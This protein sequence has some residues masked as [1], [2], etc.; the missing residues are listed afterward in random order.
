[1]ETRLG[2]D[3]A[4]V[5][6]VLSEQV[7]IGLLVINPSGEMEFA[8]SRARTLLGCGDDLT[9][10][11]CHTDVQSAIKAIVS[12]IRNGEVQSMQQEVRFEHNGA[13]GNIVLEAYAIEEDECSG[14][15]ILVKD[16]ASMRRMAQDLRMSAQF[17]NTRRLYQ[18]V[19]HDLRQPISAVMVHLDLLRERFGD[20]DDGEVE[21]NPP[22]K[23]IGVIRNQVTDL[24][25]ALTLLLEEIEPAETE[26]RGFSLRAVLEDVIRLIEPQ[27]AQQKV[28]MHVS[29][30]EHAARMSGSRQRIKQALLNLAVNA[31]DAM[32]DGGMLRVK[33]TVRGGEA[34]ISF[35]DVGEGIEPSVLP[36]IFEM[37][38]TTKAIG[39]GVGLYVARDVVQRHGGSIQVDTE[40]GQGSHFQVRL[41]VSENGS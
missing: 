6:A 2:I 26:E 38:Y 1:M 16:A 17:R 35:R 12:A 15:L 18:A 28:E 9:V 31:L 37:H 40:V 8:S 24:N 33:L 34:I 14:V 5:F 39:T 3:F 41:P 27:A 19:V 7:E 29:I 4:A 10:H 25:R 30:D 32:Q 36:H 21:S 13:P 11:A 22:L 23:W 20:D